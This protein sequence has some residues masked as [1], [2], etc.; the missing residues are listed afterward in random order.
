MKP[1]SVPELERYPHT[2]PLESIPGL[3]I[4]HD[5]TSPRYIARL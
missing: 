2:I 3:L 5:K 4:L 1:R